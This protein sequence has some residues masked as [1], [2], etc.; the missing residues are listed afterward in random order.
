ML[1]SVVATRASAEEARMAVTEKLARFVVDTNYES[2]PEEAL[3]AAK[4]AILDT[5]AVTI[6]GCRE[7]ASRIITAYVRELGSDGEAGIVGGGFR[8]AAA[9]AALANGA[10]AHA[11]DYDDV[12]MSMRGHPSAP[13]LPAVLALAEKRGASGREVIVA[14]VLGFEVECKVG[15]AIG[16]SHYSHGWH[17]TATLG[18]LGAAAASAKLLG[19]DSAA[20]RAALGIVTSLTGG[21]RQ[22]FGTMTKALHAGVAA[23]N[24]VLAAILAQKGFSADLDIIEAPLGFLSLFGHPDDYEA[25][26]VVVSLGQPFDIVRPGIGVKLYPCC[27]ATHR[28]LDAVLALKQQEGIEA[29]RVE[30]AEVKVSRGTAMPLIH[31]RPQTGLEGKFSME[32]C[33]AAALLDG[34]VNLA[35]FSDE[36]VR[37]PQAQDLLRRVE[38]VEQGRGSEGPIGGT[39]TVTLTLDDGSQH[40]HRV[41]IPRAPLTWDELAAKYRDCAVGVISGEVSARSLEIISNLEAAPDIRQLMD[42]A[43]LTPAR[44]G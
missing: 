3:I 14:F 8:A 22:N 18:S 15:A 34:R 24:G 40:S 41:D 5:L 27:Y 28:A 4:R 35:S 2:I 33:L 13:L 19:L 16:A 7:D 37:R 39:A 42:I 36:A 20:T 9:E 6:A 38:T 44:L 21:S 25:E 1:I 43:C 12:S 30:R 17:P 23:R 32:Y 10:F 29:Q 31:H 11:L 26:K